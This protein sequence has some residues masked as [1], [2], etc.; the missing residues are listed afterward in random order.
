LTGTKISSDNKTAVSI[1]SVPYFKGYPPQFGSR[2]QKVQYDTEM[3]EG[4]ILP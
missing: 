3:P 2:L 1:T 4:W